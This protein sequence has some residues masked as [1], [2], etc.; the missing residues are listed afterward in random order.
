MTLQITIGILIPFFGT[1]L[2][3]ACVF[4]MKKG[5]PPSVDRAISGFAG[6]VMT[7]ASVFSLLLPAIER[8]A[9]LERFAFLPASV[10]F[11]VGVL[12]LL[13]ADVI[14]PHLHFGG[15]T[16]GPK[17]RL[18]RNMMLT[19]AV[20]IHNFPEGMA[21]GVVYASLLIGST[22]TEY[23]GALA[24]SIGIA[25]QNFPEGAIISMPLKAGGM[26]KIRAFSVSFLSGVV[27]PL[28]ALLMIAAAKLFLPILPYVL[29]FA[30]G[31]MVFAVVEEL[32]P[33]SEVGGH[34]NASTVMF[35]FGFV[36]M[37]ALD[38]ALG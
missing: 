15:K 18:G 13:L 19:L 10:G 17:S 3:G 32:M 11:A 29:G 34:K 21:V 7:A 38:I 36:L 26:S 20:G 4:F 9:S 6:G 5:V 24:L 1:V 8:S 37:M 25:V 27:E 35:A 2:G 22:P 16:E 30:A 33:G 12:F 28:G 14:I 23:A 31:A